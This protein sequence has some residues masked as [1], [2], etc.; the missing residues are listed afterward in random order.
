MADQTDEEKQRAS[1]KALLDEWAD[2]RDAK[3]AAKAAEDEAN[4][5]PKG[6]LGG[7]LG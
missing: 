7:L 5:K 2:E 6:L 1:L 3:K 4:R